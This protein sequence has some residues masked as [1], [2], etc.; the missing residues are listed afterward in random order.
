MKLDGLERVLN[1]AVAIPRP[2]RAAWMLN[3]ADQLMGRE[4]SD[5]AVCA[6]IDAADRMIGTAWRSMHGA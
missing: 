1:R 4:L 5:A 2:W 3:F 6:A